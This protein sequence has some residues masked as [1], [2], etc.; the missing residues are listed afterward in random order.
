MQIPWEHKWTKLHTRHDLTLHCK[1]N[2]IEKSS[3]S[4]FTT[5]QHLIMANIPE[6]S[7]F[8]A[9]SGLFV[10]SIICLTAYESSIVGSKSSEMQWIT[11]AL[12]MSLIFSFVGVV[13][14]FIASD[15]FVGQMSE[16]G[17]A[18]LLLLSC[19]CSLALAL[20]ILLP[21]CCFLAVALS[22]V[23]RLLLLC[24]S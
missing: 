8:Q 22:A 14:H 21:C 9:W 5:L 11:A 6:G 19:S 20:L 16:G 17:L 24:C 10:F 13:V 15:K 23:T 4:D 1:S 2:Q 3:I 12:S 7:R 18:L